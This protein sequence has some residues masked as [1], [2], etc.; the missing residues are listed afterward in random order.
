VSGWQVLGEERLLDRWPWVRVTR[1]RLRLEDGTTFI[2]DWYQVDIAPFAVVFA[3]TA[4]GRV[5]LVEQYRH[6]LQEQV[7]ELPAGHVTDEETPL[8]A[9][10]RELLE[11]TG[12][13]SD[14]WEALGEWVVDPNRG[15]GTAYAFLARQ[16]VLAAKPVPVDLQ[17]QTV[18]YLPLDQVWAM[19]RQGQFPV[20][21]TV[22]TLGMGFA[23]LDR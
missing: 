21:A 5:A 9:A 1:Q 2:D 16:A 20:L 22:A 12:L 17:A 13:Q 11:E 23:R 8:V 4:D 7:L 6:A 14:H 10:Q 3:L 19:F 18:R 15:C